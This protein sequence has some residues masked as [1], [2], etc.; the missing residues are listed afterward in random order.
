MEQRILL[1][2]LLFCASRQA[3]PL[4]FLSNFLLFYIALFELKYIFFVSSIIGLKKGTRHF[5]YYFLTWTGLLVSLT[6]RSH[7][8]LGQKIF[9]SPRET[10]ADPVSLCSKFSKQ[11]STLIVLSNAAFHLEQFFRP[12]RHENGQKNLIRN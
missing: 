11:K 9:F 6:F 7:R 3:T 8:P 1:D 5:S 10:S 4:G 12:F 2:V